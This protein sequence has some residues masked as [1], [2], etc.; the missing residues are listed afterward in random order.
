MNS[1]VTRIFNLINRA[2]LSGYLFAFTV[3]V[4][5]NNVLVNLIRNVPLFPKYR[6]E[7]TL[8]ARVCKSVN[9]AIVSWPFV[10][11]LFLKIVGLLVTFILL[12]KNYWKVLHAPMRYLLT[13]EF[14]CSVLFFLLHLASAIRPFEIDAYFF[15][16]EPFHFFFFVHKMGPWPGFAVV[17]IISAFLLKRLGLLTVWDTVLKVA[18]TLLSYLMYL[19]LAWLWFGRV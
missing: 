12:K 8:A 2:T 4:L 13:I 17:G 3:W 5:Y 7:L 9:P 16:A 11:F 18:F 15:A 19:G 6:F 10:S 1:I 14:T